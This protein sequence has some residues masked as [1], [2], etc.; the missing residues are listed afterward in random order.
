M[1]LRIGVAV[2]VGMAGL[3]ATAP[4]S[5][6]DCSY[7]YN[8]DGFPRWSDSCSTVMSPGRFG[9]LTM[10]KTMVAKARELD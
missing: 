5:A 7:T 3:G 9:P 8:Q 2:V 6:A 1:M 4:L 10:G